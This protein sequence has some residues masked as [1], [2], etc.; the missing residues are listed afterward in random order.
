MLGFF[1][2]PGISQLN[3]LFANA[4]YFSSINS[5]IISIYWYF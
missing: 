2:L 3:Q 5:T 4:T 1:L